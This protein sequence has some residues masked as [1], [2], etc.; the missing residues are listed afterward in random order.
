MSSRVDGDDGGAK[1]WAT[2]LPPYIPSFFKMWHLQNLEVTLGKKRRRIEASIADAEVLAS[3]SLSS[4]SLA[5]PLDPLASPLPS[6]LPGRS[7]IIGLSHL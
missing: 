7:P 2:N 1:P 4:Q 5:P 3:S 6:I